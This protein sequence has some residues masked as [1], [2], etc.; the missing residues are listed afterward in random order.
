MDHIPDHVLHTILGFLHLQGVAPQTV[1]FGIGQAAAGR[2]GCKVLEDAKSDLIYLRAGKIL[3]QII[4]AFDLGPVRQLAL[5]IRLDLLE[6][7]TGIIILKNDAPGINPAVT[8]T[9]DSRTPV[10]LDAL[11]KGQ[12]L[13]VFLEWRNIRRGIGWRLGDDFR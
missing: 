7:A 5:R 4:D 6:P 12:A 13:G 1:Q 3:F 9:A 11:T 2:I 8:G 10:L